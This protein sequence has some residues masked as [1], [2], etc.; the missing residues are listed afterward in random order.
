MSGNTIL[1]ADDD[2][3][4]RT[5]LTQALG[6]VGYETKAASNAATLWRWVSDGEGDLVVTDVVI[7]AATGLR[8]AIM[9][10]VRK[11]EGKITRQ[12][13]KAHKRKIK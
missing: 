10:C 1:I 12:R 2:A 7:S 13:I 9:L 11:K 4:I 5:V 3:A 8:F 6:R